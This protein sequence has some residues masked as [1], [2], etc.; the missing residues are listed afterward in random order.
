MPLLFASAGLAVLL[1]V[2]LSALG[3][4]SPAAAAAVRPV[5]GR[6]DAAVVVA[7]Y[8]DFQCPS[9]EA[10]F[11]TVEPQLKTAYIDTGRVRLEWHDFAWIG[12]ESRDAANAAR[13]AGAQGAFWAYH[14]VLYEHQ[15]GENSGAFTLDRLKA[16]G[17]QLGL[18]PSR[19]DACVDGGT[20]SAAVA[21]DTALAA[22]LGLTGTPAFVI[23]SP[24]AIGQRIIGA[25]LFNTFAAAINAAL[26]AR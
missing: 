9:C 19:F 16:F 6:P 20:Y 8:G 14:D 18:V 24:G 5:L 1:V 26:A 3:S 17:A 11:R 15:A 13:C 12:Q 2:G 22:Q 4:G 10:F 7:E 23:G 21:A 25:Q